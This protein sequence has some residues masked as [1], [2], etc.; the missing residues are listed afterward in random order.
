MG[1][2]QRNKG[3]AFEREIANDLTKVVARPVKRKLGQARDSGNDIDL[4]PF[5]IECK[6][7]AKIGVYVWLKQCIAACVPGDI[8]VV[9]ARADAQ[10][11]IVVMLYEDFKKLAAGFLLQKMD[12]FT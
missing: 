6:R 5:R 9:I 1:R 4:P 7:Y 10:D 11:A 12:I 8:P 3:A 2:M